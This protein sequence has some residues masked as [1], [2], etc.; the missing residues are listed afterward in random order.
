LLTKDEIAA[1]A[2][3]RG[4]A[5]WQEEK[6]YVQ[7]LILYSLKNAQLIFK[8][9]TYLWFFQGLDRFSDD[10]DFTQESELEE[11]LPEL[12]S[13]TTRLF[14][15]M[16]EC[17]LVKDDRYTLSFRVD[18]RGPLYATRNDLCRVYVE[19]SRREK[20]EK[21]PLSVKFDEPLYGLPL[22]FLKGM[23][24]SEV[25]AEKIR[26]IERR[27]Q[28][29]DLYDLWFLLKRRDVPFDGKLA[30]HKLSFYN[31]KFEI[32]DI[33]AVLERMDENWSKELKPM[34]MGELPPHGQVRDDIMEI[35]HQQ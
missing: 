3:R 12:I 9:G 7:A 23:D 14:G 2:K 22:V 19:V 16:C 34:V 31:K 6:R 29:R 11:E 27:R 15:L 30:S 8:G 26:A 25:V 10:L 20:V 33:D 13:S 4:L 24:L 5:Q 28:A 32:T 21:A 1:L 18:A 17:K 35:L